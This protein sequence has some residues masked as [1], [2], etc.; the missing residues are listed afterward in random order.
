MGELV[1]VV[2][3]DLRPWAPAIAIRTAS[4]MVTVCKCDWPSFVSENSAAWSST[5]F[6]PR[7][8]RVTSSR[9]RTWNCISTRPKG[10]ASVERVQCCYLYSMKWQWP[11]GQRPDRTQWRTRVNEIR[12]NEVYRCTKYMELIGEKTGGGN[13]E[14]GKIPLHPYRFSTVIVK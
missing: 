14:R 2:P 11:R 7:I 5:L 4:L 3:R 12:L 9:L 13:W 1:P 10:T 8:C 6:L